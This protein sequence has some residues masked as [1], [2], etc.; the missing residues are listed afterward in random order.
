MDLKANKQVVQVQR[1]SLKATICLSTSTRW[2][3]SASIA[4]QP[5]AQ[6]YRQTPRQRGDE[7]ANLK[8]SKKVKANNQEVQVQRAAVK[9]TTCLSTSTRWKSPA[10]IALSP[11]A[12]WQEALIRSD[13]ANL[14]AIRGLKAVSMPVGRKFTASCCPTWGSA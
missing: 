1:A 2:M 3:S 12:R 5:K 14:K 13:T 7:T 11:A 9:A 8:A 10:P 6:S 4:L